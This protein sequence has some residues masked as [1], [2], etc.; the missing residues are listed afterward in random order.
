MKIATKLL[1]RNR[2]IYVQVMEFRFQGFLF[3]CISFPKLTGSSLEMHKTQ[4]QAT[5]LV[6]GWSWDLGVASGLPIPP[7]PLAG[8]KQQCAP[9]HT[10]VLSWSQGEDHRR[11]P[12]WPRSHLEVRGSKWVC[13]TTGFWTSTVQQLAVWGWAKGDKKI[14]VLPSVCLWPRSIIS[15]RNWRE[16]EIKH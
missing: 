14:R 3:A 4:T 16:V 12:G 13:R 8:P 6:W 7:S 11:S 15:T 9:L 2:Q 5:W 10:G 1:V